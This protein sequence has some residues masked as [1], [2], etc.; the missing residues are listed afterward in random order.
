[1]NVDLTHLFAF[2]MT[3][4]SLSYDKDM[5]NTSRVNSK[6]PRICNETQCHILHA[7]HVGVA[8]LNP[9]RDIQKDS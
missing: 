3:S 6:K 2:L 4:C 1:M 8:E 7:N 9:E 5:L